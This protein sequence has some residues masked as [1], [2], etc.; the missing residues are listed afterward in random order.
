ML[1][2]HGEKGEKHRILLSA[3]DA[4]DGLLLTAAIATCTKSLKSDYVQVAI[5]LDPMLGVSKNIH[6]ETWT[7]KALV[8][9]KTAT[10]LRAKMAKMQQQC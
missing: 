8:S 10:V 6:S 7:Q 2:L 3:I 1:L 4:V 5:A 9:E